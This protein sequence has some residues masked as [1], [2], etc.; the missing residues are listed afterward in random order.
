MSLSSSNMNNNNN[1]KKT[2]VKKAVKSEG[3]RYF[4]ASR[5]QPFVITLIS[6][7]MAFKKI[8]R[9]IHA[10]NRIK[11]LK[12][13]NQSVKTN[14]AKLKSVIHNS[15]TGLIIGREGGE[16]LKIPE[17][18]DFLSLMEAPK[19]Y[20]YYEDPTVKAIL[21][22]KEKNKLKKKKINY[23]LLAARHIKEH[24]SKILRNA[25]PNAGEKIRA[26]LIIENIIKNKGVEAKAVTVTAPSTE[27]EFASS[28]N[29]M[30]MEYLPKTP[31]T[32][33]SNIALQAYHGG[34]MSLWDVVNLK[35]SA[36]KILPHTKFKILKSN[37]LSF[38]GNVLY[39]DAVWLQSTS[40]L[41]VLGAF[42]EMNVRSGSG[43]GGQIKPALISCRKNHIFKAQQYGRWIVLNKKDPIGTLGHQVGHLDKVIL[44][45]EWYYLSSVSPYT[46]GM[47]KIKED[48][49][50]ALQ[51]GLDLFYPPDECGW[52]F[53]LVD[54]PDSN[55]EEDV[56][57]NQILFNAMNQIISSKKRRVI[58][59]QELLMPIQK[60]I[61]E[62][63][64]GDAI[65]KNQ[66]L[67]KLIP[68]DNT[69]VLAQ[70]FVEMS[71]K[72]FTNKQG[73]KDFIKRIYGATSAVYIYM[74]FVESMKAYH[75]YGEGKLPIF[76]KTVAD[77]LGSGPTHKS[78][79]EKADDH[80]WH[81]AQK[82]LT[83]VKAWN[84][85]I[86]A[87]KIYFELDATKK[88]RSIKVI[89]KFLRRCLDVK[90]SWARSMRLVDEVSAEKEAKRRS[91]ILLLGGDFDEE[92]PITDDI[93]NSNTTTGSFSLLNDG[94]N[95]ANYEVIDPAINRHRSRSMSSDYFAQFKDFQNDIFLET[96]EDDNSQQVENPTAEGKSRQL[97]LTMP[98]LGYM[99]PVPIPLGSPMSTKR[100]I[101]PK[102]SGSLLSPS[103][104]DT[105]FFE[106]PESRGRESPIINKVVSP[107]AARRCE[108]SHSPTRRPQSRGVL[109]RSLSAP[110]GNNSLAGPSIDTDFNI[111][112]LV[113]GYPSIASDNMSYNKG[114]KTSSHEKIH[115][116]LSFDSNVSMKSSSSNYKKK[117]LKLPSDIIENEVIKTNLSADTGMKFLRAISS[118][119]VSKIGMF[120]EII[121]KK[122]PFTSS[123]IL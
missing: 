117:M 78:D 99:S 85:L 68:D 56:H 49:D 44:E 105:S 73:S 50:D 30:V 66:L 36:H 65:V 64:S 75:D 47:F 114:S 70:K 62:S 20:N 33:G 103:A 17:N 91:N 58:K 22:R 6:A 9:I 89:Q 111:G 82:V 55:N 8:A 27:H 116:Q 110:S 121:V 123:S 57:T 80:Y 67:H 34:Y 21:V 118:K 19:K 88:L 113:I 31:I 46:S 12:T 5:T 32:Y 83:D 54:L 43:V 25:I 60:K 122:K 97:K 24:Q 3:S 63:K 42:Y 35:A 72:N 92:N 76:V 51:S 61:P 15:N 11:K 119:S 29:G 40:G 93:E 109:A 52:K 101:R 87:M 120:D 13:K 69:R 14:S 95:N 26:T 28:S 71:N 37:E 115:R 23:T 104:G 41:D 84:E 16:A 7:V 53:H 2:S 106:I 96:E 79:L 1:V 81:E 100:N 86:K 98:V 18:V 48:I 10:N 112:S 45:Q 39:G 107:S 102:T 38:L 94:N 108:T 4:S 74:V 59:A 77:E 90:F